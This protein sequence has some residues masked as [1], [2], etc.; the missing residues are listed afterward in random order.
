MSSKHSRGFNHFV[1]LVQK[2]SRKELFDLNVEDMLEN[3][4]FVQCTTPYHIDLTQEYFHQKEVVN[5]HNDGNK[6]VSECSCNVKKKKKTSADS[7]E[8]EN[9]EEEQKE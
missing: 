5:E 2:D 1:P 4:Q 7:E 9:E 8:E 6:Y 3:A